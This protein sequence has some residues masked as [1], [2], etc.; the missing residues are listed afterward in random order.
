MV[1]QWALG[2]RF[3]NRASLIQSVTKTGAFTG[4]PYI[5]SP[6]P[7]LPVFSCLQTN[8]TADVLA[9]KTTSNLP[10]TTIS[11]TAQNHGIYLRYYEMSGISHTSS[12]TPLLTQDDSRGSSP[13]PKGNLLSCCSV[14]PRLASRFPFLLAVFIHAVLVAV[15][16]AASYFS[17][18][19]NVPGAYD[20][21]V[22]NQSGVS[23]SLVPL[24][25]VGFELMR[26]VVDCDRRTW[27]YDRFEQPHA[28][29][30]M[31]DRGVWGIRPSEGRRRV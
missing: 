22:Y 23:F 28:D 13:V 12:S 5:I 2:Q 16:G 14:F 4:S 7:P 3:T 18:G 30:R 10:S 1:Y 27:L 21:L 8:S 6:T 20:G 29:D 19:H 24:A 17:Y 11:L 26:R 15:I 31:G 25:P 9:S